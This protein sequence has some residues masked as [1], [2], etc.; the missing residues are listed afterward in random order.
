MSWLSTQECSSATRLSSYRN[1]QPSAMWAQDPAFLK[2][3]GGAAYNPGQFSDEQ[4][5]EPTSG[6]LSCSGFSVGLHRKRKVRTEARQITPVRRLSEAR[7]CSGVCA[8]TPKD[9]F[10][11]DFLEAEVLAASDS[12]GPRTS[13]DCPESAPAIASD[14]AKVPKEKI[15]RQSAELPQTAADGRTTMML[16]NLPNNYSRPDLRERKKRAAAG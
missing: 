13:S 4:D 15:S 16:R 3:T 9:W 5:Q 10:P 8:R 14:T 7:S 6:D 11:M 2:Y 1:L 12:H